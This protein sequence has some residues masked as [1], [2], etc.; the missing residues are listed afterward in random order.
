MAAN[1]KV[2]K[3]YL[4]FDLSTAAVSLPGTKQSGK[5]GR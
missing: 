5:Q 4:N 1:G 3:N 2:K